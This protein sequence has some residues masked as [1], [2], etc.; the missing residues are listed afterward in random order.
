MS[1][2]D[3]NILN[4]WKPYKFNI[5]KY[6]TQSNQYNQ[7]IQHNY[8][9]SIELNNNNNNNNNNTNTDNTVYFVTVSSEQQHITNNNN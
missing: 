8:N 4:K 3:N 9:N 1:V 7:S 6:N 5:I 2:V